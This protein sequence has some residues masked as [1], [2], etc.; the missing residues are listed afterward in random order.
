MTETYLGITLLW[1]KLKSSRVACTGMSERLRLMVRNWTV[2]RKGGVTKLSAKTEVS[3]GTIYS[4][5]DEAAYS[6]RS[7]IAYKLALGCDASE[8]EA[9]AIAAGCLSER[10][11][12]QSA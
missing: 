3:V 12:K 6:P 7:D 5:R 11:G 2:I 4:V 9:R 1:C 8:E 10:D